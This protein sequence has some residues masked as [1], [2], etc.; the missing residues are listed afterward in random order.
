MR[1][2]DNRCIGQ[3]RQAELGCFLYHTRELRII[4][5]LSRNKFHQHL[6]SHKNLRAHNLPPRPSTI[7]SPATPMSV[8][9]CHQRSPYIQLPTVSSIDIYGASAWVL[10]PGLE[11]QPHLNTS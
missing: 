3:V 1:S 4:P 7:R 8:T 9:L 11:E 5:I 6:E 10:V 2:Q